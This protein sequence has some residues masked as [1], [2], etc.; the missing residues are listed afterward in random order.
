MLEFNQACEIVYKHFE[1]TK[2]IKGIFAAYDAG[3]CWLFLGLDFPPDVV[4]YGDGPV[5][6]NKENGEGYYYPYSHPD[7]LQKYLKAEEIEIPEKYR[8]KY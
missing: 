8:T 7:Y 2:D 4:Q 3:D 5:A 1:K 6:I